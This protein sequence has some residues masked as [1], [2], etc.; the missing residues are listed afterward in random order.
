M[1]EDDLPFDQRKKTA[2]SFRNIIRKSLE[3][4]GPRQLAIN[5]EHINN[6]TDFVKNEQLDFST[7]NRRESLLIL[8]TEQN[9]L[10]TCLNDI[11]SKTVKKETANKLCEDELEDK[12]MNENFNDFREMFLAKVNSATKKVSPKNSLQMQLHNTDKITR[13]LTVLG[14]PVNKRRGSKTESFFKKDIMSAV[15]N[16]TG[17]KLY[18][19]KTRDKISM[20]LLGKLTGNKPDSKKSFKEIYEIKKDSSNSL[21]EAQEMSLSQEARMKNERFRVLEKKNII[22]D[23][24]SE[25]EV[26]WD[27]GSPFLIHPDS[28]FKEFWDVIIFLITLY[29]I[30]Y[31]PYTMAFIDVPSMTQII[32]DFISDIFYIIDLIFHFF[33]PIKTKNNADDKYIKSHSL[34]SVNYLFSWF[35]LDFMS[36]MPFNSILNF[37]QMISD[38]DNYYNNRLSKITSIAKLSRIYKIMKLFKLLK[39]IKIAGH[40]K[41]NFHDRID[42]IDQYNIS[43]TAKRLVLFFLYFIILNHMLACIWVFIGSLTY[44][45][46][47]VVQNLADAANSDLYIASLYFNLVTIFTIGYGDIV[48]TNL[49]EQIYNI[50]LLLLGISTYTYAVSSISYIIER[51]DERTVIYNKNIDYLEDI[52]L[53]HKIPPKLYGRILRFLKY[54]YL[55]NKTD[56]YLLLDELP[57]ILKNEVIHKMYNELLSNFKFFK[58][59]NNSEFNIRVVACLRPLKAVK[60]DILISEGDHIEELLFVKRGILV[61]E[62]A[63]K[64]HIIKILEIRKNEHF[65]EIEMLLNMKCRF[66][67]RVKS[68]F[69]ELYFIKKTD[70]IDI[71]TEYQETF[72]IITQRSS[73]NMLQIT[74]LV[75]QLQTKIDIQERIKMVEIRRKSGLKRKST[76]YSLESLDNEERQYQEIIDK[77]LEKLIMDL[78]S[79]VGNTGHTETTQY[80]LDRKISQLVSNTSQLKMSLGN[81]SLALMKYKRQSHMFFP[82]PSLSGGS[83]ADKHSDNESSKHNKRNSSQQFRVKR[84]SD[85]SLLTERQSRLNSK[86]NMNLNCSKSNNTRNTIKSRNTVKSRNSNVSEILEKHSQGDFEMGTVILKNEINKSLHDSSM[87]LKDPKSFYSLF[88]QKSKDQRE[89]NEN[90]RANKKL[91]SI[92]KLFI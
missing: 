16:A 7:M 47:I 88:L 77:E 39:F 89:Q 86:M 79:K 78:G 91:D 28:K 57:T 84:Q 80:T 75:H 90:E 40:E 19:S 71:G 5:T 11:V 10:E 66:C 2:P 68:K 55:V 76:I 49:F 73:Y 23:S 27:E 20:D 37:V 62:K 21:I 64:S 13:M 1:N 58:S 42:I 4:T 63:Y 44:P 54:D 53:K 12:I 69:S 60:G 45:N 52:R 32:L 35:V 83:V 22:Y 30:I 82:H 85:H 34:I 74:A 14:T 56:N 18:P 67:V 59:T 87:N 9:F 24:R 3:G 25:D 65:G 36:S 31:V 38:D 15:S 43:V 26:E 70:L 92:L 8:R 81:S 29:N 41:G 6:A 48:S 33:I 50:I 51:S 61:I 72:E 46:W 17:P